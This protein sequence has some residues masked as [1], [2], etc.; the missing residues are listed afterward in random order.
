M[1]PQMFFPA[2]FLLQPFGKRELHWT[3]K[4]T[5]KLQEVLEIRFPSYKP[6]QINMLLWW[7][8]VLYFSYGLE[9]LFYHGCSW[10]GQTGLRCVQ[11]LFNFG[12]IGP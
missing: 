2:E 11:A 8:A 5:V 9:L 10:P 3:A 12:N 1:G 7:K 4:N 6:S